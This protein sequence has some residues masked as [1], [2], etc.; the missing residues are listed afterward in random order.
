[1]IKYIKN[2]IGR[3]FCIQDLPDYF[4]QDKTFLI[5]II[6]IASLIKT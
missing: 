3:K 2:K 1:M 5:F 6:D 4:N